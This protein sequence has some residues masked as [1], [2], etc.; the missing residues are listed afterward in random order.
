MKSLKTKS[1]LMNIISYLWNSLNS[2]DWRYASSCWSLL[3]TENSNFPMGTKNKECDAYKS[4]KM[5]CACQIC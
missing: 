2:V 1:D 4:M 5:I 3:R